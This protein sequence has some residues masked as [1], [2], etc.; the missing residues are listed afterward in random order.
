MKLISNCLFRQSGG[1]FLNSNQN[2][3]NRNKILEQDKLYQFSQ[4]AEKVGNAMKSTGDDIAGCG[5]L[6][7]LFVTIPVILLLIF[8]L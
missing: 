2:Q 1:A 3:D 5:C 4:K 6:I 7:T 8:V